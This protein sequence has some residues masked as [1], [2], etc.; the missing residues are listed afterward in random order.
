MNFYL[1]V[2]CFYAVFLEW[3]EN[4]YNMFFIVIVN[5]N[6]FL[7]CVVGIILLWNYSSILLWDLNWLLYF[8]VFL[9]KVRNVLRV[10]A[11]T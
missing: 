9:K 4:I 10:E 2:Y 11:I 1:K 3:K 5:Y 7:K 6:Y 8:P